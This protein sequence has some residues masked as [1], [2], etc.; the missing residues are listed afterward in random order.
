LFI[1]PSPSWIKASTL[2]MD[3]SRVE[4]HV[5]PLV[6]GHTVISLTSDD[7]DRMQRDIAAGKTATPHRK[8][9][10]RGIAR[11]GS[12]VAGRTVGTLTTVLEY[13][14][15]MKLITSNPARD[16]RRLPEGG[17]CDSSISTR[18]QRWAGRCASSRSGE[19]TPSGS[20]RFDSC[21]CRG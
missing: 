2:A 7:I 11:G 15:R 20:L 18:S 21:F 8:T 1:S 3:R 9:G 17:S 4:T 16:G 14:R 13:A 10:R 19:G 5:K 6:G 12:V